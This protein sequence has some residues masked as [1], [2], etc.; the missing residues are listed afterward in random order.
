MEA[1]HQPNPSEI[2]YSHKLEK[3]WKFLF[4]SLSLDWQVRNKELLESLKSK[5][6]P[7]TNLLIIHKDW[8]MIKV[9]MYLI[10]TLVSKNIDLN[11]KVYLP[12]FSVGQLKTM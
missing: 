6:H 7:Y 11:I 4:S 8:K 9:C 12:S 3:S 2:N 5:D 10:N 1:W